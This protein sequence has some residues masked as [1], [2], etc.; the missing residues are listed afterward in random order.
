MFYVN[1]PIGNG[2]KYAET[3]GGLG[4]IE[5][6]S[7]EEAENAY[8]PSEYTTEYPRVIMKNKPDCYYDINGKEITWRP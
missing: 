7:L 3:N 2:Y 8:Y 1:V 4:W 5:C 6:S